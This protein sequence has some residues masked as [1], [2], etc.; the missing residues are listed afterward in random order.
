MKFLSLIDKRSELI[1]SSIY[2]GKKGAE[3]FSLKSRI[4]GYRFARF[5]FQKVS[6]AFKTI[7][8]FGRSYDMHFQINSPYKLADF[9][10]KYNLFI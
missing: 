10:R 5:D 7:G 6:K 8:L 2:L 3:N 9:L 4:P 1:F